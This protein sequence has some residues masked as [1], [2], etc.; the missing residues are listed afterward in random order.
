MEH[1]G[2][3]IYHVHRFISEVVKSIC[4]DPR[5]HEELWNGYLLEELM[6]SYRRA[7]DHARF[8]LRIEREGSPLTL[9]HSFSG[10]IQK[11]RTD[12]LVHEITKLGV[13][14]VEHP[15]RDPQAKQRSHENY[16]FL[17]P[18]Q[19]QYL[20]INKGNATQVREHMHDLLSSYYGVAR[21]RFVDVI[22][23]QAV[24]HYLLFGEESPLKIFNTEMVLSLNEEQLDMI[25]AED[26]PVKQRREKLVRDIDNLV[27]A[28]KVLKGSR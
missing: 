15:Q 1:M 17:K 21:K 3:I 23:Q 18:S 16:L 13:E 24:N 9:T 27:E 22:Y 5:V 7:M 2:V 6:T 14:R 19:L 11:L 4:P 8:L 12:R 10:H 26:A 25:A 20:D 28:L